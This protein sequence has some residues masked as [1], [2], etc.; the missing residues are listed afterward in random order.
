MEEVLLLSC[1]SSTGTQGKQVDLEFLRLND[2]VE[3]KEVGSYIYHHL[4][5]RD[6]VQ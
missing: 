2:L 1:E 6:E 5:L 3:P 4:D